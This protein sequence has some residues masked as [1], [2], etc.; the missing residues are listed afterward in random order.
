MSY[1]QRHEEDITAYRD[2]TTSDYKKQFSHQSHAPK[3][4]AKDAIDSLRR[5]LPGGVKPEQ[6]CG[7]ARWLLVV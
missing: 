4:A 6:Y 1:W 7:G 5:K 2:R 3:G